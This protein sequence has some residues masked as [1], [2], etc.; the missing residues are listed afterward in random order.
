MVFE[1]EVLTYAALRARIEQAAR[2]LQAEFGIGRG[3]RVA[4]LSLNRPDYL[5]LLY[6]CARLGAMLVPLNW[7]LAAAEQSFIL[8]RCRGQAVG[9][10]TGLRR[11]SAGA[12]RGPACD[13][14]DRVRLCPATRRHRSIGCWRKR[15]GSG[16]ISDAESVVPAADRLHLRHHGQA[17]RRRAA[18]GGVAV[19]RDDEPAHA[20]PLLG[21]S[22]PDR[23][24]VLPCRRPQHP[25]HAGAASR[26]HRDHPFPLHAGGRARHHRPRPP[27]LDGA[28][29]GDDPGHERPSG[30]GAHRSV[31]AAR[32]IDRID[33]RAAASDPTPGRA[34]RARAPGLRLDRNLPG[35]GLHPPRRRSV[36]CRFDRPARP[37]L[38]S[39]RG[40][41]Q[42]PRAAAGR[43]G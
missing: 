22:C 19:E 8:D 18:A 42:W 26:R 38:R 32:G 41:R 5:V 37:V 30:L 27:D 35:C 43:A 31:L 7:R 11:H 9:A 13:R 17:E 34:R 16:R 10:R 24:A 2:A 36:A 4:V 33:H 28:G 20:R 1:G 23:A 29:A 14:R 3:D 21:R 25:D 6:A 12:R 40:G 15:R 39:G